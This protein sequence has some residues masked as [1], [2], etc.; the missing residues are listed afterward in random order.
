MIDGIHVLLLEDDFAARNMMELLL[1][2]DWRTKVTK[3]A[4]NPEEL[5]VILDGVRKHKERI[6]LILIDTDIPLD[7]YH[8]MSDALSHLDQ[9]T[10]VTPVLFSGIK[11]DA[12]V[13]RMRARSNFAGYI[14]K[15]EIRFS[16]A[17][18]VVLAADHRIIVT[19]GTY[20]LYGRENPLPHGTLILDGRRPIAGF[21]EQDA[22]RARMALIF[23][24]QRH[25]MADELGTS[26][27][28]SYGIVSS[29]FEKMGLNE[30]FNGDVKPEQFFE[31]HPAVHPH[32]EKII[33]HVHRTTSKKAVDIETL[34]FHFLT[35]PEIEEIH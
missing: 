12:K 7:P 16:L 9:K 34:A 29:L 13:A 33:E 27:D 3:A 30:L 6:D 18:A 14:L 28:Y 25:E 21:T 11:P 4:K 17:W 15:D 32:L 19:P 24:M 10:P 23:S 22:E 20:E 26:E 2:R 31:T 8:W 35:L 5:S 1:R